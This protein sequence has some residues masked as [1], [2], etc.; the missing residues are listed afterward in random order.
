MKSRS[1]HPSRGGEMDNV[2][3]YLAPYDPWETLQ[4]FQKNRFPGSADFGATSVFVGTMR[5]YNLGDGVTAMSLEHYP[6]MTEKHLK[7]IIEEA[8]QRWDILDAMI[9]HRVG[10]ISPAEPIVVTAAW[11]AHRRESMAACEYLIEE[12]K[13]RAPFWKKETLGNGDERWVESN[14]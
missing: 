9:A 5:D 14:T 3:L 8:K 7:T 12:L 4:A 10:E 2:S 11:S 6:G 13:H 1:F